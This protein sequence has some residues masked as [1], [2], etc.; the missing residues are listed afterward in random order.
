[1]QK[2]L[3]LLLAAML[4]FLAACS[5]PLKQANPT[6]QPQTNPLVP[7]KTTPITLTATDVQLVFDGKGKPYMLHSYLPGFFADDIT[8]VGPYTDQAEDYGAK[9]FCYYSLNDQE[10]IDVGTLPN[11]SVSSGDEVVLHGSYYTWWSLGKGTIGRDTFHNV[12]FKVDPEKKELTILREEKT[13]FSPFDKEGQLQKTISAPAV[14]EFLSK[15]SPLWFR[16]VGDYFSLWQYSTPLSR[17]FKIEG[18]VIVPVT[19]ILQEA[20]FSTS[21]SQENCPYLYWTVAPDYNTQG[22]T[23]I[24]REF[25]ILDTRTGNI[26]QCNV[27]IDSENPSLN[28]TG[29]MF[30]NEAGD[31]LLT[32]QHAYMADAG[33]F[34]DEPCIYWVKRQTIDRLLA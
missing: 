32:M 5:V 27:E 33:G 10:L 6:I 1:M 25:S 31:L 34:V 13:A 21:W 14:M 18:D 3:G 28:G 23:A 29:V 30:S 16:M 9:R 24:M 22:E 19:E 26:R 12:F 8:F 2:S 20:T 17:L 15:D 11:L 4:L 7:L